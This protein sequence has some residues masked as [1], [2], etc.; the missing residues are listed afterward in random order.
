[1]FYGLFHNSF[2]NLGRFCYTLQFRKG[3]EVA[4]FMLGSARAEQ[5]LV[6]S[7]SGLVLKLVIFPLYQA[8]LG[9]TA[10]TSKVTYTFALTVFITCLFLF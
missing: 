10:I 6:L 7:R 8:V 9:F 4:Q 1:M 3:L 2:N 5:G